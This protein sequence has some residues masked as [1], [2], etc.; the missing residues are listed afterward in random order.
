MNTSFKSRLDTLEREHTLLID[1]RNLKK[2][3]SN[4]IF[5][6]Y[7][8]PILTAEHAPLEWR[9]DFNPTSN[10]YLMER[11]GIN[12]IFNAGAIKVDGKYLVVARVEG[13]DRKSFFAVAESDNGIDGFKFW[14]YPVEMPENEM[15]DTN[16][17]DMRVVKHEDGWIYGLFCTERR[18]QSAH[19]GDQSAAIAQCGIARTKDLRSWERL[20]DLKTPSPQQRNVVLHPEFVDGKYAFYTRPQDSFI[21]AG[22]GGG[23]GFGLSSSIEEAVVEQEI[24]I[25]RKVY[26]TVYEAKNGLGPAPIK[27]EHGW[28]HLAHGVRNTAAGLRYVLYMF[29]T[30]LHDITKVVHK[31]AG[32]FM[33]P[34]G[35]E[36]IGDVSNV[37]FSN[38]WIVDEDG[39][40][41]IYYASS[42]TRQHVAT[43]TVNKLVDYVMNTPE[44]QLRSSKTVEA[45]AAMVDSNKKLN[46]TAE[47]VSI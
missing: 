38:G 26:H 34:E 19:E 27:T 7:E 12:A 23:I 8:Y 43:S 28:L 5:D 39:T 16:V 2:T 1:R 18:D 15:P 25:D 11:C 36:R 35:E 21:E 4:G 46:G 6:R 3:S 44:D 40:V 10:P 20:A 31:P 24:V 32:Y 45:I 33:A 42:D 47:P 22:K 37:L 13:L 9:Y 14:D 41:F 30:D 29:M 17:Y